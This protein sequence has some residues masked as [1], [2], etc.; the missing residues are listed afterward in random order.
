MCGQLADEK[1]LFARCR[2]PAAACFSLPTTSFCGAPLP[3]CSSTYLLGEFSM[4]TD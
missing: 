1:L 4:L 2:A 3:V